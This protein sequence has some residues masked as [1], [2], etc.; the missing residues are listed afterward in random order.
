[1]D[2]TPRANRTHIGIFGIRNAGKSTLMNYLLGQ[3]LAIVADHKGTTTDP[4]YKAVELPA[5]GPAVLIDTP[6]LDDVDDLGIQRVYKAKAVIKK[7]DIGLYVFS[8][9]KIKEEKRYYEDLKAKIG[10]LIP[11]VS[12]KKNY[13]KTLEIIGQEIKDTPLVIDTKDQ[14][15]KVQILEELK[16]YYKEDKNTI[17][18]ELVQKQDLVLLVIPVDIQAPKGRLILAQVQT[19]RDI[20]DKSAMSLVTT[21]DN[22]DQA[23]ASL[24]GPPDLVITDSQIFDKVYEKLPQDTRL[25]SFSVLYAGYKGDLSYYL[26]S[27]RQV[28]DL[29]HK[30]KVLIAESC[31]HHP[32]HD[33]IGKVQ[34]PRIL[35]DKYQVQ[36]ANIDH[37]RG[38]DYPE[39]LRPYDMIIHCGACTFNPSHMEHRIKE[40]KDQQV[41]MTNYGIFLADAKGILEKIVY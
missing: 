33:D 22:M 2:K 11:L 37:I 34:I 15:S 27:Q 19:I 17:T 24:A 26:K 38:D 32:G 20:L 39:D 8:G 25:S 31:S 18:R 36:K 4:V 14:K 7:T 5:L 10:L 28:K 41:P 13:K 30:S 9:E 35:V 12:K 21:L 3:D 29:N 1:M 23:L 6:G 40:A 16:K